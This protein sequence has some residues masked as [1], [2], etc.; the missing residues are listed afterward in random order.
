MAQPEYRSF[1]QGDEESLVALWNSQLV[2]DPISLDLFCR[3]TLA[4][5]N[6][7]EDGLPV[8]FSGGAM[9]GFAL[10]VAPGTPRVFAQ[11]PGIGRLSAI[12]VDPAF[13][14]QGVGNSLLERAMAF[15]KKRVCTR[16]VT[17]APEYFTA[18]VD[19][20]AYQAAVVFLNRRGFTMSGE[21][22]GMGR[23]LV[24]LSWPSEGRVAESRTKAEGIEV[25]TFRPRDTMSVTAFFREEF[26]DWLWYFE[27]KLGREDPPDDIIVA[28]RSGNVI[29]YCQRLES[30][31][32]GPFGMAKA[33]RGRG[34][35]TV[36]LFRLLE[37]M[38]RRGFRF[39]WFGETGRA[40]TYY[41]RAGF[42]VL[43]RYAVM[44]RDLTVP[45]PRG[46]R[47]V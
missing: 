5:P 31:H 6:F 8:A 7:A 23:K 30:D 38:A 28:V 35:G 45:P 24:D 3:Q 13:R 47:S 22:V 9:V 29:G 16:A 33:W 1:R 11:P 4:D 39:A 27:L 19:L 10:V 21:A 43:R 37:S 17:V 42:E 46:E 18:G 12:A 40:R 2:R 32:V 14:K 34:I 41:E 20:D 25:R 26:P 15:L 36:M 44:E